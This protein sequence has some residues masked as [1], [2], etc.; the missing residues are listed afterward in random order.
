MVKDRGVTTIDGA[1][2]RHFDVV[3]DSEKLLAYIEQLAAARQETIDREGMSRAIE[4]L[5]ATG[6]MWIDA[7]T[8][9]LRRVLWT[10]ESLQTAQGVLS[11][12]FTAHLSEF[13]TAP[14]ITP[15]AD[16]QVLS[17]ASFFGLTDVQQEPGAT[18]SPEKLEQLRSLLEGT[19]AIAPPSERDDHATRSSR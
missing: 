10:I 15:P 8:Y 5:Q 6:E 19:S 3:L 4:N 9:A 7:E 14:I 11:G 13:D 1:S 18:L 16:A 2:V 12:S 17:P